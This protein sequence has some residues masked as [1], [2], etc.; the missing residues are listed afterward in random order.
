MTITVAA[1]VTERIASFVVDHDLRNAPAELFKRATRAVIDTV[2]VAI[3][4]R[5][6]PSFTILARTVGESDSG[7][8]TVLP[9]RQRSSATQA[10][11]LNGTAGHAL[12]FDDVSDTMKGHPSVVLVST[13]LALAESEA[14]SGR[15]LLEAYIV[16][17]EVACAIARGLPVDPHYSAG[18]H[19]TA[20]VGILGATA[21]ACRLVNLDTFITRNALG[22]AA[23]MAGGSRQNFGT[24]TKPLHAGLVARDAVLAAQLAANGFTADEHQLEGPLG[25]FALYGVNPD[26]TAVMDSLKAPPVLLDQGLDVKKYP[27]CYMTHRM[28]DAALTLHSR[29]IDVDEVRA[30]KVNMEPGGLEPIMHHRPQTGLQGKFSG[31]YVVAA[32]LLDGAVG[33]TTFTDA[34][35]ARPD[36]QDLLQRVTITESVV[37][38][39]GDSHFEHAYA[40]L[41]LELTDGTELRQ[42]CD[43]PRGDARA[44]LTDHEPEAK[45]RDCLAFAASEWNTDALLQALR[46]LPSP[47]DRVA[48][49][50][51]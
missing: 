48:D 15:D 51:K 26:L 43:I 49:L 44:P 4:G 40:T 31:E 35:V 21:G 24:M 14:S 10:A 12:D 50:L 18:W 22:I 34:A 19:A 2:G 39:F 32:G 8:A 25:Y 23:S 11:L 7:V 41:Q 29:G 9:T 33:L 38:P 5:R 45:F 13:L 3:A 20:T 42:R 30:V 36:A 28:A 6:E 1:P 27:C 37:P 17:F 46:R 16:G 47:T